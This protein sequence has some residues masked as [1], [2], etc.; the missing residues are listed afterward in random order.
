M[1]SMTLGASKMR[2][3]KDEKRKKIQVFWREGKKLRRGGQIAKS[4]GKEVFENKGATTPDCWKAAAGVG[5][6]GEKREVNF[7]SVGGGKEGTP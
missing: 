6:G 3:K 1:Q 5:T 7:Q 2:G 4:G